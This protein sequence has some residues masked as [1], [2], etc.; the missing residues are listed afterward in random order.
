[1]KP[2]AIAFTVMPRDGQLPG[3]RLRKANHARFAGAI[4]ALAGV[5]DEADD[6]GNVNDAAR[7]LLEKE[8]RKGF[9]E[10]ER[11]LEIDVQHGVPVRFAH[12]H[13]PA[14]LG[15]AGVVDQDVHFAGRRDDLVPRR[16][17]AR[18]VSDVGANAPRLA[19][20]CLGLLHGFSAELGLQIDAGDIRPG[21]SEFQGNGLAD[22]AAGARHYRYLIG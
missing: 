5:A 12:A 8:A 1:M 7:L 17:H 9:G 18:G 10:Q 22:T 19:T 15:D 13:E 2:G 21:S 4:V 11:A 3:G 14:V 16:L 20:E 6:G